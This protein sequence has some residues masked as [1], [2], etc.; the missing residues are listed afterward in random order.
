[1]LLVKLFYIIDQLLIL[2]C[3]LSFQFLKDIFIEAIQAV[4]TVSLDVEAILSDTIQ[5]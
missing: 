5:Q 4:R 1:M 2:Q 3:L